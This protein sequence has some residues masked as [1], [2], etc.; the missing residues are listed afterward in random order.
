T[1]WT[2]LHGASAK[3][4]LTNLPDSTPVMSNHHFLGM[5][6]TVVDL[7]YL[8]TSLMSASQGGLEMFVVD[9]QARLVAGANSRYATRQEM[10]TDQ[11]VKSFVDQVGHSK[12]VASSEF[13]MYR[14]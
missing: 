8:V 1:S 3:N 4:Q 5:L 2:A 13:Q 12:L 11:L 10:P 14:G 6:G 9:R 7:Q